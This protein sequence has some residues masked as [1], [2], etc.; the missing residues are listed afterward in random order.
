MDTEENRQRV[1]V[2][3][4]WGGWVSPASLGTFSSL[5]GWILG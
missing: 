5:G 1:E 3:Q 4:G 2:P